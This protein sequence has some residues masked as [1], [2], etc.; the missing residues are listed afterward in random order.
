MRSLPNK[1]VDVI[2]D[3]TFWRSIDSRVFNSW[4]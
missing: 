2:A 4:L 3:K 1:A